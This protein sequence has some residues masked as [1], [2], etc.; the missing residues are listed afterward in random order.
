M[1]VIGAFLGGWF[2]SLIGVGGGGLIWQ[3]IAAFV[4]AVILLWLIRL[5]APH[6]V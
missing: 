5:V 2:F 4:G 1:G 6:R 3:L